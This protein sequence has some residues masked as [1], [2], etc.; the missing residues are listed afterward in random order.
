MFTGTEY[1]ISVLAIAFTMCISSTIRNNI[2][3]CL[4][5]R[6]LTTVFNL[7]SCAFADIYSNPVTC[8]FN[9]NTRKKSHAFEIA[10]T[11]SQNEFGANR[12]VMKVKYLQTMFLK[13]NHISYNS[14]A[15]SDDSWYVVLMEEIDP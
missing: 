4:K 2:Q 15:N 5:I 12:K 10:I 8:N 13:T 9:V 1:H 14:R 3:R 6:R 11:I 7:K